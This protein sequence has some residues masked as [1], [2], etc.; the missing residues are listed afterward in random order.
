MKS[1][2]ILVILILLTI[3]TSDVILQQ[4]DDD[5]CPFHYCP[6]LKFICAYDGRGFQYFRNRCF[7][8]WHNYCFGTKYRETNYMRGCVE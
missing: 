3:M 6:S 4:Y 7:M 2:R 5:L 1:L 8:L